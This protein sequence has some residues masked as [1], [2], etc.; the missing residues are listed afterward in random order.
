MN[1]DGLPH[2]DAAFNIDN[3][4]LRVDRDLLRVVS[5][6]STIVYVDTRRA[7]LDGRGTPR[8]ME[9]VSV[10]TEPVGDTE[11]RWLPLLGVRSI[12][13]I[14]HDDGSSA[15][16]LLLSEKE[17]V[18]RLGYCHLM[19]YDLN[20]WIEGWFIDE[21]TQRIERLDRMRSPK[22]RAANNAGGRRP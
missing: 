7:L 8:F 1:G 2:S 19:Y 17:G 11:N 3:V 9:S 13:V 15:L 18:L 21:P 6:A 20:P 14:V 10:A 4:N 16:D 12:P 5:A 22:S